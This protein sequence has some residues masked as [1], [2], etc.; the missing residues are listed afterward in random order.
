M[1]PISDPEA[2]L[3]REL[4]CIKIKIQRLFNKQRLNKDYL[5]KCLC[6]HL[7]EDNCSGAGEA[8]ETLEI[9]A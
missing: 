7:V 1:D 8:D 2:K 9:L 6:F 3:L 5:I 4:L